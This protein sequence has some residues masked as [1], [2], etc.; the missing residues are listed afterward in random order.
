MTTNNVTIILS[1]KKVV[2]G[3][4]SCIQRIYQHMFHQNAKIYVQKG[5]ILMER[6]PPEIKK[7]DE[8]RNDQSFRKK[9]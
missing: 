1:V 4:I 2:K 9:K 7:N 6:I 5:V 8:K 3:V